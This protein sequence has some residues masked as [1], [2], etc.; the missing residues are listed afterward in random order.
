LIVGFG[1]FGRPLEVSCIKRRSDN[2]VKTSFQNKFQDWKCAVIGSANTSITLTVAGLEN[3]PV[4]CP[5]GS[6]R[7]AF[8]LVA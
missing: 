1:R 4:V 3:T 6:S 2:F 7:P 8:L 5:E